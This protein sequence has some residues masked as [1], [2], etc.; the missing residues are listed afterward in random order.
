MAPF[1]ELYGKKCRSPLY[2]DDISET[3]DVEPDMIREMTE[4]VKLIQKRMKTAQYRQ[5]KYENIRQRP[6]SFDQGDRYQPDSSHI[7]QS[8]K[9]ELDETLSYFEQPIQILD[10]KEKQLKNKT[11]QLVKVQWRRHGTEEATWEIERL[12]QIAYDFE[13]ELMS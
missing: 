6:I 2:W 13:D 5:A 7:I 4:K 8:D 12:I 1:E 10:R 9:A 3:P 11:I